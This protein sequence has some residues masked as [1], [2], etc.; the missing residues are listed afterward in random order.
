MKVFFKITTIL[1]LAA[2]VFLPIQ[3]V[4]ARGLAEGPIFG[5]NYT[6]KS[7]M[8]LNQDLVVFGGSV[9]IEKDATVNG[10]IV[11]FG[12]SLTQDGLVNKDVVVMGGAVSLA[13]NAHIKGNL[14]TFGATLS[15]DEGARVD[16][17]VL[18][19]QATGITPSVPGIPSVPTVPV[20][21]GQSD[22]PVWNALGILGQSLMLALLAV[23]IAMFLPRQM[24]KVADGVVAQPLMSFGMGLLALIAFIVIIVALALFSLLIITLLVT[25]PLI[26]VISIVFSAA[27]VLGWLALGLE[28]GVRISQMT[29]REWPLPLAAGVGMFGLNLV[30]Q[31]IGFIPCIGGLLSGLLLLAGLG[32]VLMTRFGTHTPSIVQVSSEPAVAPAVES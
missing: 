11:I 2:L 16:G 21:N 4:S 6:L 8:T 27:C 22:N 24:R 18:N 30:A 17:D 20:V 28:V 29:K 1:L 7:G 31:G 32:A 9:L 10:A 3:A 19:N 13:S 23:L 25:V 12:G 14:V 15:R 26:I 5:S